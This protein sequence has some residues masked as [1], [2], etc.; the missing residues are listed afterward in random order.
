M[1]TPTPNLG[2]VKPDMSDE[3]DQTIP[4]MATNFGVIDAA[5]GKLSELTTVNK[6]SLVSAINENSNGLTALKADVTQRAF[7]VKSAPYNAKGDGVSND[8]VA[9][10]LVSADI[11]AAGGGKLIIPPG[12]YIV[13]KQT[14]AGSTGLGY[15]YQAQNIIRITGCTKP[16]VIEGNGAILKAD[17]TLKFG[18]FDPVTGEVYT[19]SSMPF[20]NTDYIGNAYIGM[21][22]LDNNRSVEVS[23]IELDGNI[24]NI[25]LGGTWGD[26]GRQLGA[27]GIKCVDNSN[28]KGWNIYTHHHCLDGIYVQTTG[29][30]TSTLSNPHVLD[31]IISEWNAR[32]GMSW[33]GGKGLTV[34]N[35]K[36]NHTGNGRFGSSPQAGL[37]IEPADSMAR[38]GLFINCEFINN[39]G[40]QI[41]AESADGGYTTFRKCT[42]WGTNGRALWPNK[43]RMVFEDCRIFGSVVNMYGSPN[44]LD[45]TKFIRCHFED[46]VH[47]LYPSTLSYTYLLDISGSGGENVLFDGC[48]FESTTKK[49]LS[50]N[51]TVNKY[52]RNCTIMH[53]NDSLADLSFQAVL[54]GV[55]LDRVRFMESYATPPATGYFISVSGSLYTTLGDVIVDGPKTKWANATSGMIG[56][57]GSNQYQPRQYL[58]LHKRAN[59]YDL[60][61]NTII[62]SGIAAPTT[63][64]YT[65]GD[66]FI[67]SNLTVGG[68]G[69]WQCT[70]DGTPGTWTPV[71][72]GVLTSISA[73]PLGIGF[74]ALSGGLLYMAKGTSSSADWVQ[75]S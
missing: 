57:I 35:S 69:Y 49:T 52:L 54:A 6:S 66:I 43:P 19:P 72:I 33:T 70:A 21:I 42:I 60:Y 75:I 38:D 15:A 12:T 30:S 44:A 28:L 14:F 13:G 74:R 16:V 17:P 65:K 46:K 26:T 10:Q 41:V 58:T 48:Y 5:T 40:T 36:F 62:G 29:V 39:K 4:S 32:Q 24:D 20:L 55:V 64:D 71:Q 61:G 9:F 31:N 37:D 25:V 18:A 22:Y 56:N 63:G 59:T 23:N 47:A 68:V 34:S 8:T 51:G 67:N 73:T 27:T 3:V 11:N 45:A 1:A 50:L 2:L 53:K 7:N